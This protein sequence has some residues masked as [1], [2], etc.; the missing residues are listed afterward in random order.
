MS[1][2]REAEIAS[3]HRD[4][5]WDP[6]ERWTVIQRTIEWAAEQLPI[7]P[8]SPKARLLE[9]QRRLKQLG[10]TP[11]DTAAETPTTS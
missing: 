7:H 3:K 11:E 6:V 5:M 2:D 8:N 10:L 4:K 9:Q 1:E